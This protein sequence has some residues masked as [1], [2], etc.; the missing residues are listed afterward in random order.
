MKVIKKRE[1]KIMLSKTILNK[2]DE[3]TALLIFSYISYKRF[4]LIFIIYI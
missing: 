4:L 2:K 1:K 3:S